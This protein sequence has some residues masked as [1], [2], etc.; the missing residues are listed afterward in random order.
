MRRAVP[1]VVH[2]TLGQSNPS[3]VNLSKPYRWRK[4]PGW[5]PGDMRY[6]EDVV[7]RTSQVSPERA[8]RIAEF[9][10]YRDEGLS[11]TEAGQRM[12]IAP[13]TARTYERERRALGKAAQ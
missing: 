4:I 6:R 5:I 13:S 8:Q 11:V 9:G 2:S 12:G 10:G 3:H 1:D 7:A